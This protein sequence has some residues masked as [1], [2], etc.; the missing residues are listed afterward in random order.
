MIKAEKILLGDDLWPKVSDFGVAKLKRKEKEN[1]INKSC[2]IKV[3]MDTITPKADAY[4]FGMALL[5]QNKKHLQWIVQIGTFLC[6][7]FGEAYQAHV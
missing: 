6:G 4:S 1:V 3:G 7:H 2:M 5:E